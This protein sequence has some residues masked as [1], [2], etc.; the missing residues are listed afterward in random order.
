MRRQVLAVSLLLASLSVAAQNPSSARRITLPTSKQL[1]LPVPGVMASL[2]GFTPTIAISPDQRFAAF[3]NDGY[4]TQTNGAHQ[5]IAILNLR[6]NQLTD[7]PDDRLG[8]NAK[9]SYFIGLAFS[10][11][12]QRLY[13]SVGSIADPPGAQ[14][15]DT[16]NGIAV[17]AFNEGKVVPDTFFKIAPQPIAKGKA[18]ASALRK[19]GEGTAV[20]YP[21]GL[22]IIPGSGGEKDKLLVVNNYSDT[23]S[24]L[25]ARSGSSLA[26][27]D[28][29]F[30]NAVPSSFPYTAVASR[31]GRRAWVSLWNLSQVAELDL[32][33]GTVTRLIGTMGLGSDPNV[34]GSH[35][36]ALLLSP[37]EKKLYVALA[38]QDLVAVVSTELG[39]VSAFLALAQR[40]EPNYRGAYPTALA[41]SE[42]GKRLYVAESGLN[43]VA[44]YEVSK[45]PGTSEQAEMRRD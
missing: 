39:K 21:A 19:G 5:S 33:H 14:P 18:V 28:L 23:A 25:E 22:T 45:I 44:V 32:Q 11:D 34:P 29:S 20:P 37:D 42:D 10:S 26:R 31:D 35:P 38:N 8:E 4:G 30:R 9:Q 7:F 41:Q 6:S 27:I 24:L 40:G 43:A 36:C 12:G 15:G 16:G 2:N 17:Y 1:T 3:L 13:A